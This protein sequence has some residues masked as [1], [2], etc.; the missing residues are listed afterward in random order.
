MDSAIDLLFKNIESISTVEIIAVFFGLIS[1][2]FAWKQNIWVFP[3]GIISVLL[4]VY[5]CALYGLYADMSINVFY[6]VMSVFGW[7]N[8]THTNGKAKIRPI[9]RT[10][11]LEKI[12]LSISFI[13]SLVLIR[14]FLINFT[15]S[16]VPNIDALTTAV[17]IIG[18]WLMALKK[19]ENWTLWIIGDL[20]S[21]PLYA[22]KG[23]VLTSIQFL[24][25]LIIAIAGYLSWYKILKQ[26]ANDK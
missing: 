3:T 5:I 25:F 23:L 12:L 22:Y 20:I 15:D 1:V 10:T 9:S 11:T 18:M 2:L 4:Y 7:Y 16:T 17:F 14:Y 21:I 13:V 6:F 8:W 24:V 26:S 19:I